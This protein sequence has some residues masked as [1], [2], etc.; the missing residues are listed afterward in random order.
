MNKSKGGMTFTY[1]N[2]FIF[3][4]KNDKAAIEDIQKTDDTEKPRKPYRSHQLSAY[5][6]SWK[7][8]E[9]HPNFMM[10]SPQNHGELFRTAAPS[11]SIGKNMQYDRY[12]YCDS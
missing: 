9:K 3:D 11:N 5:H 1:F 12:H 4:A 7:K 6:W 8:R 2:S 10:V